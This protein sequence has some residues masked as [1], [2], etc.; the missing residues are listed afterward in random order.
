[1]DLF[2]DNA[3]CHGTV[4][5]I[6]I[7]HNVRVVFLPKRTISVLQ[8]LDLGVIACFKKH[9]QQKR[10]QRAVDLIGNNYFISIYRV[11]L[12]MGIT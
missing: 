9:Y 7:L 12:K 3:S 8:P 6:S 10:S 1:M 5:T 4:E 2:I 11:D